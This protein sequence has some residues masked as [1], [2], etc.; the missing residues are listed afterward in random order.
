MTIEFWIGSLLAIPLGIIASLL[1]PWIVKTINN[2]TYRNRQKNLENARK[3][4]EQIC[5]FYKNKQDLSIYYLNV[6]V[7]TTLLSAFMALASGLLLAGGQIVMMAFDIDRKYSG[8]LFGL[9]QLV[10][11]FGSIAIVSICKPALNIWNKIRNFK[12]YEEELKSRNII[13]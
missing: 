6:V 4:Y 9:A 1:T 2:R 5:E 13:A 11:L 8:I 7:K 12:E 3:E 10:N